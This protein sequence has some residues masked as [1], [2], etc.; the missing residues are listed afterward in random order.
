MRRV[1]RRNAAVP[2]VPAEHAA[3]RS[4]SSITTPR[5]PRGHGDEAVGE[6]VHRLAGVEHRLGE[7]APVLPQLAARDRQRVGLEV[8]PCPCAWRPGRRRTARASPRARGAR[9]RRR[10]AAARGRCITR[11]HTGP[12]PWLRRSAAIEPD[13]VAVDAGPRRHATAARRRRNRPCTRSAAIDELVE[14]D[15][16]DERGARQLGTL[17]IVTSARRLSRRSPGREGVLARPPAPARARGG[18]AAAR[19]PS[20]CSRPSRGPP[21]CRPRAC[22]RW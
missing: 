16:L 4:T 17:R 9:R 5:S 18:G 6:A 14:L 12:G 1:I 11:T 19:R 22:S 2:G 13:G 7:A 21:A 8:R 10:A 3:R 15:A 20:C